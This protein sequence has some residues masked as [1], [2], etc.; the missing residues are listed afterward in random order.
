[1]VSDMCDFNGTKVLQEVMN[2]TGRGR[3]STLKWP[4]QKRPGAKSRELWKIVMNMIAD[5]EGVLIN[6]LGR[7]VRNPDQE[8]NYF[9]K[10][11]VEYDINGE[12]ELHPT[13]S[14]RQD[15]INGFENLDKHEKKV[16]G[17]MEINRNVTKELKTVW[18]KGGKLVAATDGG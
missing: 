11:R 3:K 2:V 5:D 15:M 14:I 1:M 12:T 10:M 4:Q 17:K 13:Q 6:V 18:N 16:L 8:L 9:E 7:W